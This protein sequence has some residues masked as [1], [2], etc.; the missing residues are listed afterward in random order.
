MSAGAE[1]TTVLAFGGNALCP[2]GARGTYEEQRAR[3]AEMAAVVTALAGGPRLRLA[4]ITSPQHA[5]V[6]LAGEHGTRIVP[7]PG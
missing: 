7:G 6:A 4:V 3:A 1:P 2:S 5:T